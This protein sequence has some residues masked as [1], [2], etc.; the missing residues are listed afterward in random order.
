MRFVAKPKQ[1]L[2][3]DAFG[4]LSSAFWLG[5][6]FVAFESTFGFP[7]NTL[8]LLALMPCLFAA[9]D[10]FCF[11]AVKKNLGFHVRTIAVLNLLY[12]FLSVALSV[13]HHETVTVWGWSYV[14]VELAI[15][16]VLVVVEMKTA[17]RLMTA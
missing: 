15:I 11:F 6:V 16:L 4:A 5:I 9:Y 17:A 2:I 8:Y 14:A 3:L 10:F 12:C 1:L 13:Y 7:L